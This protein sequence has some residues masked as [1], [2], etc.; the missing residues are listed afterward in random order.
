[1]EYEECVS[2]VKYIDSV[3]LSKRSDAT[4]EIISFI[5]EW[6]SLRRRGQDIMHTP[7]GYVC[8]GRPLSIEHAFFVTSHGVDNGV[9]ESYRTSGVITETQEDEDEDEDEKRYDV[10]ES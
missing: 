3:S 4:T 8:R 6:V 10:E 5:Q 7:L 1:M 2:L 9:V